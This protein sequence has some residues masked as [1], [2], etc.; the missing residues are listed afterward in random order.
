METGHAQTLANAQK[1]NTTGQT[2]YGFVGDCG[3]EGKTGEVSMNMAQEFGHTSTNT[4]FGGK[5]DP[6]G[7]VTYTVLPNSISKNKASNGGSLKPLANKQLKTG[8]INVEMEAVLIDANQSSFGK[9]VEI[10]ICN[11]CKESGYGN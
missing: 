10:R 9:V 5:D 6:N 4:D 11:G 2:K 1:L 3:P 8:K 7:Q